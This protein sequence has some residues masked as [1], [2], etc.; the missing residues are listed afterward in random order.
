LADN[1][2]MACNEG[3][4]IDQHN[5]YL[6]YG[7]RLARTLNLSSVSGIGIY[8]NWNDENIEE[9]IL[10]QVYENLY[11]N[12]D[13][14]KKYDF[15]SQPDIVSICLGA[16][17]LS[18]GDGI[19]SRLP[20]NKEKYTENYINFVENVYSHYS[21]TKIIL[22]NSPMVFSDRNTTLVACLKNV[23]QH[24]KN[25]GIKIFEFDKLLVNGCN[26]HPSIQ[27]HKEISSQ[28]MPLFKSVL[29]K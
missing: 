11:L 28:L 29:N 1:S 3:D 17:D 20:F 7:P 6:A 25:K 14:S 22:L 9:L 26:Y 10:S 27:D 18:D 12:T 21:K 19:K 16:N 13:A 8:R 15:K 2:G 5:A 23:Q 24:F 4:C